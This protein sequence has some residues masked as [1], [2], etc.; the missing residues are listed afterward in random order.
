MPAIDITRVF[1]EFLITSF[2]APKYTPVISESFY[3][4]EPPIRESILFTHVVLK[5]WECESVGVILVSIWYNYTSEVLLSDINLH[6]NIFFLLVYHNS[7]PH[8][9][10]FDHTKNEVL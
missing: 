10:T 4:W 9:K 8:T 7:L 5:R 2:A 1:H 6:I 3:R